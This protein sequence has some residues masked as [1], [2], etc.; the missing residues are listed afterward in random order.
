MSDPNNVAIPKSCWAECTAS[1]WYPKNWD[2][3]PKI[4][5]QAAA[6]TLFVC[7]ALAT[8]SALM[9]NY[10]Q[11]SGA[12][13][14]LFGVAGAGS[15]ILLIIGIVKM[16]QKEKEY[17]G[18]NEFLDS[19]TDTSELKSTLLNKFDSRT[20]P[21]VLSNEASKLGQQVTDGLNKLNPFINNNNNNT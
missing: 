20:P 15:I 19:V 5:V 11:V 21:Q 14:T 18:F 12:F 16:W 7:A 10:P 6:I 4:V 9:V 1:K 8:F 3:S 2:V 17:E 13:F